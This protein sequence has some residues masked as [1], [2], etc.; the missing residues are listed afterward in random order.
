MS[1]EKRDVP[2][3]CI[4]LPCYNEE[5]VLP[6]TIEQLSSKLLQLVEA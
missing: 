6:S 2:R 1:A 3:L 4:I 5:E